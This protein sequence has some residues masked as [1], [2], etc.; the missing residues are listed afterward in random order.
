MGAA[1]LPHIYRSVDI[2]RFPKPPR[3]EAQRLE[4][5][6]VTARVATIPVVLISAA[7][8][9]RDCLARCL[10]APDLNYTLHGY[11]SVDEWHPAD[12]AVPMT[13]LL[14]ATGDRATER[15]IC[16][17]IA[18]LKAKAPASRIIVLS[19]AEDAVLVR[20]AVEQ[21]AQGFVGMTFNLD[22]AAAAIRLV[23]A[24]ERFV[25]VTSLLAAQAAPVPA[26]DKGALCQ[27][28]TQRQL[29]VIDRLRRGESNK[30]IAYKLDMSE[31]T[32]KIH[33]RNIMRKIKARNRTEVAILT[34][35]LFD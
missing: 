23:Q 13:I 35:D 7:A 29:D 6:A 4:A 26:S 30:I 8:L 5:L 10:A 31:S 18:K 25:P 34:K 20:R 17:D 19:D 16:D 9:I 22:M 3:N 33:I 27:A 1:T 24:G 21:G 11:A 15:A 32:V 14:C 12:L 2:D 28:L